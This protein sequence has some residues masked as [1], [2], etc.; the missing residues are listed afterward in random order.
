MNH[1]DIDLLWLAEIR[2]FQETGL[3]D[4]EYRQNERE[5]RIGYVALFLKMGKE[6]AM[7]LVFP[8]GGE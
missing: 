5:L 1:I 8:K 3:Y 7:K 4:F 6:K 2:V